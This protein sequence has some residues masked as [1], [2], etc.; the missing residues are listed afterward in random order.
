MTPAVPPAVERVLRR[1]APDDPVRPMVELV[2]DV[3][4]PAVS[5]AVIGRL[6]REIAQSKG[7]TDGRPR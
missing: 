5:R 4:D 3:D 7:G 1:L 6:L 2:F